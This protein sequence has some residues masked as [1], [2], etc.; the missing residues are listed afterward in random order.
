MDLTPFGPSEGNFDFGWLLQNQA[1]QDEPFCHLLLS[2]YAPEIERMAA[3]FLRSPVE[4]IAA[5]DRILLTILL[6]RARYRADTPGRVWLYRLV[7]TEC[8]RGIPSRLFAPRDPFKRA[9]DAFSPNLKSGSHFAVFLDGLPREQRF[10]AALHYGQSLSA[11]EIAL[12]TGASREEVQNALAQVLQLLGEHHHGCPE[13]SAEH[14]SPAGTEAAL[15]AVLQADSALILA[16]HE[17]SAEWAGSLLARL[18]REKAGRRRG[19]W[20]RRG[21]EAGVLLLVIALGGWAST[22]TWDMET[23]FPQPTQ[24]PTRDVAQDPAVV[25]PDPTATPEPA[26]PPADVDTDSAAILTLTRSSWSRWSSLWA[27]VLVTSYQ[28]ENYWDGSGT[29][30]GDVQR[31]QIWLSQ[32]DTARVIMGQALGSPDSTYIITGDQVTG[33]NFANGKPIQSSTTDLILDADLQKLFSPIDMFASGGQFY[34]LGSDIVAQRPAWVVDW[35][36]ADKL[37]YRYWID[38]EYGVVLRRQTFG[39]GNFQPLVSD[40]SVSKIFFNAEFP[41]TIYQTDDYKGDLY[42]RDFTGAPELKDLRAGLQ[43]WTSPYRTNAVLGVA[44]PANYEFATSHLY[45]TS[46]PAGWMQSA[47][48][49]RLEVFA[50]QYDLGKLPLGGSSILSCQRSAN[51]VKIAY[52]SP[53]RDQYGNTALFLADLSALPAGRAV[54]TNGITAG[55][56]AFSPDSTRLA[57]FG[58]DKTS[59]FCGVFVLDVA[60]GKLTEL[61]PLVYADYISWSP[62]GR[63]LALVGEVDRSADNPKYSMNLLM[64]NLLELANTWFYIVVDAR[65]ANVTYKQPFQWSEMSAPAGSPARQWGT[66]FNPNALGNKGCVSPPQN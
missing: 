66:P 33:Q 27:D 34:R 31:K 22:H 9:L 29:Q 49:P 43:T 11:D 15:R 23:W 58:C 20:A 10:F 26:V 17:S 57:F 52:N 47:D 12:V 46:V 28:V 39:E 40:I 6:Q 62:D 25:P 60:S 36:F 21:I 2:E 30:M 18:A 5:V 65:S 32:P 24:S 37:V 19:A 44:P 35:R 56:Y 3:R 63:S 54:L 16:A 7:L 51:G 48:G 53:A 8:L 13:C 14:S 59:G 38:Q 61:L 64:N 45:F 42:V 55:G 50:G 4:R 1:I 41:G